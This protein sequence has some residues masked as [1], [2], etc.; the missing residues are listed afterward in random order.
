VGTCISIAEIYS[1]VGRID[2]DGQLQKCGTSYM[3]YVS[4]DIF[5]V[6]EVSILI[7]H[8]LCIQIV[9]NKW[10]EPLV[11]SI[12]GVNFCWIHMCVCVC[13]CET[14]AIQDQIFI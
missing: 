2:V 3:L 5:V 13:V 14:I 7:H 9:F 11:V 10:S 1:C 8:L 12:I 6:K 4:S